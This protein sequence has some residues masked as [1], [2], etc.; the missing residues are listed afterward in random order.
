MALASRA[1]LFDSFA[2]ELGRYVAPTL[3]HGITV[4]RRSA[5][6]RVTPSAIT[7]AATG[8][9]AAAHAW[10]GIDDVGHAVWRPVGHATVAAMV[11]WVAAALIALGTL[12]LTGGRSRSALIGLVAALIGLA[13]LFSA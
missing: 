13:L 7:L 9:A 4:S 5:S 10:A 8:L 3:H 6:F 1:L 12:F 11:A 2:A